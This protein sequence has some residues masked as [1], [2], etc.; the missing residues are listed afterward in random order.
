MSSRELAA[1]LP[2]ANDGPARTHLSADGRRA[3]AQAPRSAPSRPLLGARPPQPPA[4]APAARARKARPAL[5][6]RA[7]FPQRA[8]QRSNQWSLACVL[9]SGAFH[10]FVD[11]LLQQQQ[12]DED[13]AMARRHSESA[14]DL[15]LLGAPTDGEEGEPRPPPRSDLAPKEPNHVPEGGWG[16]VANLGAMLGNLPDAMQRQIGAAL[17]AT[18]SLSVTFTPEFEANRPTAHPQFYKSI[19]SRFELDLKAGG[20]ALQMVELT[21]HF[22]SSKEQVTRRSIA[23]NGEGSTSTVF[24]TRASTPPESTDSF[25]AV[26]DAS[27]KCSAK[28]HFGFC[29]GQLGH[30]HAESHPLLLRAEVRGGQPVV[31]WSNP[32]VIFARRGH[33]LVNAARG[34]AAAAA[35][36]AVAPSSLATDAAALS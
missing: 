33:N 1:L 34:A 11:G 15:L 27:G 23:S 19:V 13:A 7:A 8:I 12:R 30:G 17:F 29:G 4:A 20:A 31:A 22:A 5:A 24:T 35:A 14:Q 21:V 16:S 9:R 3:Q 25:T 10:I 28:L 32:F 2:K 36:A 6:P 18:S 26:L